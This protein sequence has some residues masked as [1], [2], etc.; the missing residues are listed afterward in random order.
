MIP[1]PHAHVTERAWSPRVTEWFN[2]CE[3]CGL[4]LRQIIEQGA[5]ALCWQPLPHWAVSDTASPE[6][7]GSRKAS[8][9]G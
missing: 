9:N 8:A 1:K 5:D 4:T 7:V 6:T 2:A 3:A